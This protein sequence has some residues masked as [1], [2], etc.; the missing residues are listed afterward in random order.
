MLRYL[1]L[2]VL[3]LLGGQA[4]ADSTPSNNTSN[5]GVGRGGTETGV[6]SAQTKILSRASDESSVLDKDSKKLDIEYTE[7]YIVNNFEMFPSRYFDRFVINK[8][9]DFSNFDQVIFFPMTFDRL[10]LS[11]KTSYKLVKNWNDSTW[12]EMDK[13]CGFFDYFAKKKFKKKKLFGLTHRGGDNVLAV[14]VRLTEFTPKVSKDGAFASNTM[15]DESLDSLGVIQYRAVVAHSQ[16]GELIAVIEDGVEIASGQLMVNNRASQNLSWRAAFKRLSNDLY[17][18][19]KELRE[20]SEEHPRV[21]D[22]P[23]TT[24]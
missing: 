14:E 13:I 11:D 18:S 5:E 10:T 1:C 7:D 19:F 9:V 21:L 20:W 16:T 4:W 22:T 8:G 23:T 6:S 24:L 2:V 12:E 3:V 17:H 15:M